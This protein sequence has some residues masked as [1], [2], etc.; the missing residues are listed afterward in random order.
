VA[1]AVGSLSTAIYF[2]MT[3][4]QVKPKRVDANTQATTP[5]DFYA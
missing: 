5:E 4:A 1:P 2:W 3:G